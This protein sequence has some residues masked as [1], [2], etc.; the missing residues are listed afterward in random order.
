MDATAAILIF[1]LGILTTMIV[2]VGIQAYHVLKDL[3]VTIEKANRV[4]D[5]TDSITQSVNLPISS[6]SDML[7]QILNGKLL[8]RLFS[9]GSEN[10]V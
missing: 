2:I 10:N 6:I 5:N 4:L 8:T 1:M 3:R 9:K 7:M